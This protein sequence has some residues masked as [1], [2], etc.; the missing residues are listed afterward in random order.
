MILTRFMNIVIKDFFLHTYRNS[1]FAIK[2]TYLSKAEKKTIP[3]NRIN[4]NF[5]FFHQN[6]VTGFIFIKRILLLK[7]SKKNC[8]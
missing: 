5:R 2:F 8:E 7:L 3:E 1:Q 4:F 6:S